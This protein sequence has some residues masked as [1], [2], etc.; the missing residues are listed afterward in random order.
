MD[1]ATVTQRVWELAEPLALTAGLELIDVQYRPE[2]GRAVLR[3][4]LDR[5]EGGITLDQLAR[6]SRELGDL[7]DAH[8]TVPG[9]YQLECSSP[10][11][12][13][14]LIREPHFRRAIG[15]RVR[16]RTRAPIAGRRQFHGT[17]EAV[18]ADAVTV[19]DPDAGTVVVP[20][21]EIEKANVEYDFNRPAGPSQAH[22]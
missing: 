10:G 15:E 12:N 6:V 3:L 11:L 8:D 19:A 16:V 4:L 2:G 9:R 20:F 7:L 22:V 1:R 13:R 21:V 5:P 14:P 18:S 17:L